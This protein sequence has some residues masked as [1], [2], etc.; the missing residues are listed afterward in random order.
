MVG[1][2][3]TVCQ[4]GG[5]VGSIAYG[6]IVRWSGNYNAPFIPMAGLLF[7]G[8]YVWP[9][10]DASQELGQQADAGISGVA[11]HA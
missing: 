1:V 9:N 11:E 7:L 4:L 2:F 10:L 8:A 6:Y 5:L 3:N